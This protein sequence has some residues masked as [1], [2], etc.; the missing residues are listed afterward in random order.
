MNNDGE[1]VRDEPSAATVRVD[2]TRCSREFRGIPGAILCPSCAALGGNVAISPCCNSTLRG[3]M[4]YGQPA[5]DCECDQTYTLHVVQSLTFGERCRH[6]V[7]ALGQKGAQR[8]KGEIGSLVLRA[9]RE[10][11]ITMV[12]LKAKEGH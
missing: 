8:T 1:D 9:A 6:I 12:E 5:F 11:G 7:E 3:T 2:C 10:L 4:L